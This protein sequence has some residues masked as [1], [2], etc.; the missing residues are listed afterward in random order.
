M[1]EKAIVIAHK[2]NKAQVEIIRSSACDSCR[3][4]AVDKKNKHFRVWVNNP[5][6][7]RIGQRVEIELKSS[8][9]LF[10]TFIAYI[11]PLLAFLVG[12]VLGYKFAYFFNITLV[13]PFALLIGIGIMSVSYL[14]IHILSSKGK[15]SNKYT[16]RIV[17]ILE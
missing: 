4:C 1:R 8:I 2:G 5:L 16:S 13:E 14:S 15:N 17:N 10:A 3:G 9:F 11:V 6:N 7:A 12:I